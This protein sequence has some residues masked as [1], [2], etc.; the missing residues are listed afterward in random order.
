M[1]ETTI[2]W[3]LSVGTTMGGAYFG[4]KLSKAVARE[5]MAEKRYSDAIDKF[6][7]ISANALVTLDP[8]P[9]KGRVDQDMFDAIR[10]IRVASTELL[11][12]VEDTETYYTDIKELEEACRDFEKYISKEKCSDDEKKP[13]TTRLTKI[14]DKIIVMSIS[15]YR[16]PN[17]NRVKKLVPL[18]S[19]IKSCLSKIVK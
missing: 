13:L 3:I 7:N 5:N 11:L 18:F 15:D 8:R 1:T 14:Q 12:C 16:V 17:K 9:M 2:T 19:K 10:Q 4:A 6:R